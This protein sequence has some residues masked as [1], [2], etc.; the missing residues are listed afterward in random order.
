MTTISV[1]NRL[2]IHELI[3][4]YSHCVDNYRGTEWSELF[5]EDGRLDGVETPLVGRQA[6]VEQ[7][8]VLK[9]GPTEYR[10]I[11]TNVYLLPGATDEQAVALAYGTVADWAFSPPIMS[12]FVEYRFELINRGDEWKI[13]RVHINRPYE[14]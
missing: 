6:F 3:A 14:K 1:E 10:H 7:S 8:D 2:A 5:L 11:I 13:A 9:A 4:Q 12:I